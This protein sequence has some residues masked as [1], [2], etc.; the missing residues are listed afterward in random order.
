M[1]THDASQH[2]AMALDANERIDYLCAA[3]S[4]AYADGQ[5]DSSE[6]NVLREMCRLLDVG[7]GAE[8]VLEAARQ[9]PEASHA[10]FE[11]I[12]Q[13]GL[14]VPL[15]TDAV[16]IAFADGQLAPGETKGIAAIVHL[17]G[18]TH[19]QAGLIGRYVEATVSGEDD[20]PLARELAEGLVRE[21]VPVSSHHPVKWLYQ[22]LRGKAG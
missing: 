2:P 15:V 4:I 11:Q 9:K 3:A 19:A 6:L 1:A 16:V 13:R 10:R 17:V 18:V 8:R 21:K 22:K 5:T 7:D 12:K 14:G 20:G